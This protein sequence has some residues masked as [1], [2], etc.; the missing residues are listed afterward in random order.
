MAMKFL[1]DQV[2]IHYYLEG[3]EQAFEVLLLRHKDKIYRS[4]YHKIREREIAEDIFQETFVKIIQTLKLGNYNEEGKFLPWA[5][6]IAQNLV[7]DYFRKHGRMKMVSERNA[8]SEDFNI[9]SILKMDELN[10]EQKMSKTELETQ[11]IQLIQHLP[12]SQKEIIEKRIFQDLSFKDIA[13]MENISINTALGRMRYALINLRKLIE[14]HQLV[15][16]LD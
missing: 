4:I 2:L 13:E 5:M 9:F 7:I 12:E 10:V 11:M 3:N 1:D 8:K 15:T 14:K 6:R 16:D